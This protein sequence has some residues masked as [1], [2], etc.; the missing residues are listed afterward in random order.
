MVIVEGAAQAPVFVSI[1]DGRVT[2]HDA[3]D[4]WGQDTE[5]T[6]R[7]VIDADRSRRQ[8]RLASV[9]RARTSCASPA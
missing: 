2:F 8:G 4:L 6:E 7:A 1:D 5:Q 3:A 9:R